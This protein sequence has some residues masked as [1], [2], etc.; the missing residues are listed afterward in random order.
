MACE[1]CG[2]KK[3]VVQ[4]GSLILTEEIDSETYGCVS[5]DL[6]ECE[7]CGNKTYTNAGMPYT[8]EKEKLEKYSPKLIVVHDYK[9]EV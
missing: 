5:A 6:Y 1:L 2:G 9:K 3:K 7:N 8:V 4:I